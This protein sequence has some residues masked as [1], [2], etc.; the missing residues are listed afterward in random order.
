MMRDAT[1]TNPIRRRQSGGFSMQ[2]LIFSRASRWICHCK[3]QIPNACFNV[4]GDV[5]RIY[6]VTKRDG[7]D[8]NLAYIPEPFKVPHTTQFDTAYMRFPGRPA[9]N[10][11]AT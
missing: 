6:D 10:V 8:F 2:P 5:S 4:I 1:P 3:I 7:T 11:T 9:V